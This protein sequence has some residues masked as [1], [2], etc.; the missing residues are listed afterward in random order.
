MFQKYIKKYK[1]N[2]SANMW[3]Q[4]LRKREMAKN[5]FRLMGDV[6]KANAF[7]NTTMQYSPHTHFVSH[8][9]HV[10]FSSEMLL[11]P[12]IPA[13]VFAKVIT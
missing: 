3:Q 12:L 4:T 2:L 6:K 1:T 9:E 11:D 10:I 13:Y 7:V 8:G 5:N